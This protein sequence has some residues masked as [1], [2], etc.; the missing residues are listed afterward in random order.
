MKK[1][2]VAIMLVGAFTSQAQTIQEIVYDDIDYYEQQLTG[3]NRQLKQT[4]TTKTV[5]IVMTFAGAGVSY[6]GGKY[7]EES[8]MTAVYAGAGISLV[9]AII[10]MCHPTRHIALQRDLTISRLGKLKQRSL[11]FSTSMNGVGLKLKL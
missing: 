6:F 11:T 2:L 10:W 3:L 7:G 1:L 5:G 8:A 4:R 9:G